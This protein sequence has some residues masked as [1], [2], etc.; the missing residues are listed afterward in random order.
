MSYSRG[1]IKGNFD[2]G[3]FIIVK[4]SK[5]NRYFEMIVDPEEAW[6]AKQKLKQIREKE[7]KDQDLEI[8]DILSSPEIDLRNIFPTYDFF[9]DV[10]KGDRVTEED[11]ELAFETTD[12]RKIAAHFLLE[13]DFAWTKQQREKWLEKKRK[14]IITILARNSINPQTKHPHPPKRIEKALEEAR[15]SI[16]INKSAEEQIEAILKQ[17]Q[18]IIP[19]RMEAI[20]MAVKIPAIY[21]PKAYNTVEQY[22]QVKQSEWQTDGSWIGVISLPAGLQMEMMDKLNKLTHGRMESKLLQN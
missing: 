19:I 21:A 4:L 5:S 22:A 15:V 3:K 20:Q 14:Q 6:K 2:L 18:T 17:I 7:K 9:E 13:G 8:D 12:E 10:K 1:E 16:D 11:L